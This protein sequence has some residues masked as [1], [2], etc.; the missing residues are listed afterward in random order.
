MIGH[1]GQEG[2]L[3]QTKARPVNMAP[4]E[5]NI[6][7]AGITQSVIE[8]GKIN[9]NPINP[10]YIS[11]EHAVGEIKKSMAS[12]QFFVSLDFSSFDQTLSQPVI[13]DAAQYFCE[14]SRAPKAVEFILNAM[15]V[16]PQ[17]VLGVKS[18][19]ATKITR[20]R[21]AAMLTGLLSGIN[22]TN[23]LGSSLNGGIF[24]GIVKELQPAR[25]THLPNGDDV[26]FGVTLN[27]GSS[28][29]PVIRAIKNVC[30][31]R[32]LII[33]WQKSL[34]SDRYCEWGQRLV[35]NDVDVYACSR[36]RYKGW[37]P[38]RHKDLGFLDS[39]MRDLST[40]DN[41]FSS[42]YFVDFLP[43]L[44]LTKE[45]TDIALKSGYFRERIRRGL[46]MAYSRGL[47]I[48]NEGVL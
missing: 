41:A 8:D 9:G 46:P 26:H 39:I 33:N 42:P 38:E 15:V 10:N 5:P 44:E 3:G 13:F 17:I 23:T 19:R 43:E 1:R 32:G 25:Y 35:T 34:V 37:F 24:K 4:A 21:V 11:N 48:K 14:L 7:I 28:V 30:S 27:R 16:K 12:H 31:K 29:E 22:A 6:C 20:I 18:D 45:E 40:A 36:A 47:N 2:S